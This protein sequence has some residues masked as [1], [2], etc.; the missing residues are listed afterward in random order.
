MLTKF[1]KK[2]G[3]YSPA[4]KAMGTCCLIIIAGF[5]LLFCAFLSLLFCILPYVMTGCFSV[6]VLLYFYFKFTDDGERG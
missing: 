2:Y 6:P 3:F 4:E 1:L 5:A